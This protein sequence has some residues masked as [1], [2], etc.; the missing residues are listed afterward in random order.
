VVVASSR[1]EDAARREADVLRKNGI[2]AGVF[3][4]ELSGSGLWFRVVIDGG[5]PTLGA[6][7]EAIGRLEAS[8]YGG[9]WVWRR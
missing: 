4:I 2:A 6:A 9:A 5:Y 1:S 8:G 3:P 7:R